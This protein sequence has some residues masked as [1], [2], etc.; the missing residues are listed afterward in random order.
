ML[1][2]WLYQHR[3]SVTCGGNKEKKLAS[4][5]ELTNETEMGIWSETA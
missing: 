4:E 3:N 2:R 1:S 5:V